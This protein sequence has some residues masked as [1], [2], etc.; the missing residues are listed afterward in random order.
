[1]C[2][3]DW[4][5]DVCSS[6]LPPPPSDDQ[7]APSPAANWFGLLLRYPFGNVLALVVEMRVPDLMRRLRVGFGQYCMPWLVFPSKE[8]AAQPKFLTNRQ[9]RFPQ[10]DD[11]QP[12][13]CAQLELIS[14]PNFFVYIRLSSLSK[15]LSIATATPG[16]PYAA[17]INGGRCKRPRKTSAMLNGK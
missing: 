7:H 8:R 11:R 14:K 3:C 2:S 15:L 9:P 4:S 12:M 6:D 16:K 5:S 1:M 17:L 10:S 13:F